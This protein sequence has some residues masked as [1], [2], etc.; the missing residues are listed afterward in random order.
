MT[1]KPYIRLKNVSKVF[2]KDP[3]AIINLVLDNID[4]TTLQNDYNHIIGLQNINID[5][6]KNM[7]QKLIV[8]Y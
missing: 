6:P 7:P 3:Q 2:G 8:R 1:S 5:I 4:K